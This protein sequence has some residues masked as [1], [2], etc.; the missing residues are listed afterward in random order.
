[1]D[2]QQRQTIL[3][4]PKVIAVGIASPIATVLTSRFGVAG[5]LLGLA[6]SAVIITAVTDLLKVYLA[7]VPG[8]V[9]R[10]P[11]GFRKKSSFRNILERMRLPFSKF[12]SLSPRR[13]RSIVMGSVVAGGISFLVGLII[14]TG[15]EVG[16]GKSL[17]CWVWDECP[18]ESSADGDEASGTRTLPSILGGANSVPSDTTQV[19][20]STPQQQPPSPGAQGVPSQPPGALGSRQSSSP[21]AEQWW[22]PSS[23]PEDQQQSEYKQRGEYQQQSEDQQRGEYQQQG[24]TNDL[25]DQQPRGS[26]QETP[27]VPPQFST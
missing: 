1:M 23:V 24:P 20:S 11:G 7:R 3:D 15:L 9:T 27:S 10:I 21:S 17:S 5:T 19:G 25:Q 26:Q 16:M 13:R 14:V 4:L 22:S 2:E 12:S 6:L 18:T 8:T